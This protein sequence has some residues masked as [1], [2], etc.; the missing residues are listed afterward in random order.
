MRIIEENNEIGY[1]D[2]DIRTS[3]L[4]TIQISIS[5]NDGYSLS[6]VAYGEW[7]SEQFK[8]K[9][10]LMKYLRECTNVCESDLNVI[11]KLRVLN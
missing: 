10:E 2:L 5:K 4:A 7:T 3:A 1:V 8:N 6:M 9:N 11:S